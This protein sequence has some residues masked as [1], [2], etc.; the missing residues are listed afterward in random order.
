M[1]A[2]A[3]QYFPR[4]QIPGNI[5]ETKCDFKSQAVFSKG[6]WKIERQKQSTSTIYCDV[7]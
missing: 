7:G 4:F 3:R 5:L 2:I 1:V 6:G